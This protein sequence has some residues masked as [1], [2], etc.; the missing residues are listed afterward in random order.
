MREWEK[1][2]WAGGQTEAE[3]IRRVGQVVAQHALALTQRGDL[4]LILAGKGHNGDDARCAREHLTNR[5]V[6]VLEVADP[7]A[8][9]AR[10]ENEL[11]SRP[12]LVIDGL[13]GIGINRSL[14]ADWQRLLE[15]INHAQLPVLA[16]DTPSGLNGDAGEPEGAAIKASVTLTVG[17]PKAGLLKESAWQFV[18]R[19]E[20]AD[21]VGLSPC[22]L[23]SELQWIMNCDF[24]QFPAPRAVATHKGSYG[25]LGILAGSLGFHGAA[26]LA[27]RGAQRAQPGLIT[28]YTLSEVYAVVASQL[29]AVMVS[30]W[31]SHAGL[32]ETITGLVVGPGLAASDLPPEL[33]PIVQKLWAESPLPM[34]MDASAL[35]WLLPGQTPLP[36]IRV[37]TPHPGEAAR[38]LNWSTKDVQADRVKAL[39]SLSRAHGHTWV[40]LKGHQ[41]LI[42]RSTG[43]IYVNSSGNPHLAQGGSGDVLSGFLGGLLSQPALQMDPIKTIA[44]AVW[45]H[46]STADRLQKS[47]PNWAVEDLVGALGQEAADR[48]Q[49]PAAS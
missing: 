12:A 9:F 10:V 14:S 2:T 47:R 37:I 15:R 35:S 18:G 40:V 17:A 42:G 8:D 16:V 11:N 36:G 3:V 34:V 7:A 22:N 43:Q 46:G 44:Y 30:I 26:V 24:A 6:T 19:L 21:E 48:K 31:Q 39:R 32:K 27:A 33:K 45:Q 28:L 29:Q 4:L 25:H 41:T 13:F 49:E 5:R 38:L 20:V 1:A 23:R